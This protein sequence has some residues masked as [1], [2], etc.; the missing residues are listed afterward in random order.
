MKTIKIGFCIFFAVLLSACI[1]KWKPGEDSTPQ[2]VYVPEP[3]QVQFTATDVI[4]EGGKEKELPF[5]I[6]YGI[7]EEQTAVIEAT[8]EADFSLVAT[9]NSANGKNLTAFP[10][11]NLQA[12]SVEIT[13]PAGSNEGS[14]NFKLINLDKLPNGDFL[15][16]LKVASVNASNGFPLHKVKHTVY[17]LISNKSAILTG[18]WLFEDASNL[19]KATIGNDLELVKMEQA[20]GN[21][22]QVDGPAGTKGIMVPRY[23]YLLCTHGIQTTESRVN[24]WTMLFDV[25]LNTAYPAPTGY[26]SLLQSNNEPNDDSD[27]FIK[28][29]GS[30]GVGSTTYK[31][32]YPKDE[33]HRIVIS[34]K[35][36]S[37]YRVFID[38]AFAFELNNGDSRITLDPVKIVL[39]GDNDGE[40]NDIDIG[41]IAIWDAAM[42]DNRVKSLGGAGNPF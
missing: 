29:D 9:Y 19:G 25:Q 32:E 18:Q 1:E 37:W 38:G 42:S 2:F 17:Y 10:A 35:Y 31:G 41:E 30:I 27:I 24:E 36:Q 23:C 34:Y 7:A 5:T 14:T 28:T 22:A 13:I 4:D 40:D 39:I 8:V 6:K 33:W 12:T 20:S 26:Y 3:Y 15:L 21:F 11:A 16:P